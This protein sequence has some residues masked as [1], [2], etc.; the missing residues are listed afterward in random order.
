MTYTYTED[1]YKVISGLS[2]NRREIADKLKRSSVHLHLQVLVLFVTLLVPDSP[3][4]QNKCSCMK[5]ISGLVA[6]SRF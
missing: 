6:S 5:G 1:S 3:C 2:M 4:L